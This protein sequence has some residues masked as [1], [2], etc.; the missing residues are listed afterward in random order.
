MKKLYVKSCLALAIPVIAFLVLPVYYHEF[1]PFQS[2]L[3]PVE[4]YINDDLSEYERISE[5]LWVV[6]SY[7]VVVL[8][9]LLFVAALCCASMLGPDSSRRD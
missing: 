4:E 5:V 1:V 6:R 3:Y 9:L 2:S 8:G 7:D